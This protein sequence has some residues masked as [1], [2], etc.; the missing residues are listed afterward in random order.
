MDFASLEEAR[1]WVEDF[2]TWYN[3]E[4]LHSGIGYVSP[5]DRHNGRDIAI[6]AARRR[7][8]E[9]ARKRNPERWARHTRNWERLEVVKA[10]P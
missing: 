4:H 2:V 10:K 9:A 1:L 7:T 6:L 3:T 8:Y 5:E